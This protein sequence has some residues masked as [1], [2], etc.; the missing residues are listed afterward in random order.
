MSRRWAVPVFVALVGVSASLTVFARFETDEKAVEEE[1]V[2]HVGQGLLRLTA[3]TEGLA[4]E[5]VRAIR[6]LFE[7]SDIVRPEQFEHFVASVRTRTSTDNHFA[8]APRVL[9]VDM[10]SFVA[11]A[12]IDQPGYAIH[13]SDSQ[14]ITEWNPDAVYWPQLFTSVGKGFGHTAGFDF[15]SD[16]GISRAI[17][18]ALFS[19]RP[20]ASAF[21]EVPGGIGGGHLVLVA[22]IW[23]DGIPI[24][25]ATSTFSLGDLLG[26]RVK[27]LLGPDAH[28]RFVEGLDQPIPQVRGQWVRSTGFAGNS[29]R[30]VVD[31]EPAP[32]SGSVDTWLL[33]LG[34][35]TS[36]SVGWLIDGS[37]RRR[38]ITL[39]LAAL[40]QILVEKDRF[41]AS[42]GHAVR[43]PM[44]AIIGTLEILSDRT[45][46]LEP[47]ERER[48]LVDAKTSALDLD[49]VTED[50]LT[51]A[52]ISSGAF[53]LKL[54]HVDLDL[55]ISRVIGA[56]EIPRGVKLTVEPIGSC[57]GD[58][59]RVRQVIRNIIG[60]AV[61]YALS[62]ITIRAQRDQ[63]LVTIE[64]RNDGLPVPD[65]VVGNLFQPFGKGT[66]IGQ[67]ETIGLGLSVGRMLARHMDGD[68]TYTFDNGEA[69]FSLSLPTGPSTA[70]QPRRYADSPV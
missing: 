52:R 53:T 49:R 50:Y 24:G 66:S 4:V 1:A 28:L 69:I 57:E 35:A 67:P 17:A 39:D 19:N 59:I 58:A 65:H 55:V 15:G 51:A 40:Q 62:T 20:R 31:Y 3:E 63:S 9:G 14:P 6:A 32:S 47:V 27:V 36:L 16:P 64:I 43:T 7:S 10:D 44:T 61:H 8:Y 38:A 29:F 42:V 33:A 30:V 26:E 5:Q 18:T 12:S 41:L 25:I 2:G 22:V 54:S 34:I 70:A 56:L 11:E 60:N 21:L 23:R 13:D 46:P 45:R 68:L 37:S 48:L